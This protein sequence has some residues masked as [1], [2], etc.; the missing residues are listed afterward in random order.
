MMEMDDNVTGFSVRASS[1]LHTVML[2]CYAE[3]YTLLPLLLLFA[4]SLP[5]WTYEHDCICCSRCALS[6]FCPDRGYGL[7]A[8]AA[9]AAAPAL[10]KGIP[11]PI[12]GRFEKDF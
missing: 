3:L 10:A 7:F 6:R 1:N 4:A 11:D 8:A 2:C 12:R 9:A 5:L